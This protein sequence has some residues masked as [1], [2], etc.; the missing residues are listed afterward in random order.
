MWRE[1]LPSALMSAHATD[2]TRTEEVRVGGQLL[3]VQ[4]QGQALRDTHTHTQPSV[5][6]LGCVLGLVWPW[7]RREAQV[8]SRATRGVHSDAHKA[9]GVG[10][11][12]CNARTTHGTHA[13]EEQ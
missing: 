1:G 10:P 11:Q 6:R 7:L 5:A 9:W 2:H 8:R 3:C 4:R 12:S 13:G